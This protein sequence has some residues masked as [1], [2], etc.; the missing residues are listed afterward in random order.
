[1]YSSPHIA[2]D[3][4][5]SASI[6]NLSLWTI[7]FWLT[8]FFVGAGYAKISEP[9]ELLTHLMIWPGLVSLDVTRTFGGLEIALALTLLLPLISWRWVEFL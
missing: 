1:M 5:L 4:R 8:L 2:R 6:R 9:V 7:Q 3:E